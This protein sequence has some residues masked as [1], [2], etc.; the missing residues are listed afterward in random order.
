VRAGLVELPFESMVRR[1]LVANAS[2]RLDDL[3]RLYAL[4][5]SLSP[6]PSPSAGGNGDGDLDGDVDRY[7][8]LRTTGISLRAAAPSSTATGEGAG[9]VVGFQVDIGGRPDWR[10]ITT[11]R[12]DELRYPVTGVVVAGPAGDDGRVGNHARAAVH[13]VGSDALAQRTALDLAAGGVAR[14]SLLVGTTDPLLPGVAGRDDLVV[15]RCRDEME[16]I[17]VLDASEEGPDEAVLA[18]EGLGGQWFDVEHLLG[19]LS[20]ERL[21]RAGGD[22]PAPP[23]Y[24]CHRG[25]VQARRMRSFVVDELIDATWVEASYFTVFGTVYRT[26]MSSYE[27]LANWPRPRRLAVAH[28][29]ASR[30]CAFEVH[31]ARHA[32]LHRSPLVG[33]VR[34][35][36]EED[37]DARLVVDIDEPPAAADLAALDPEALL[38]RLHCV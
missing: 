11:R 25:G 22:R 3:R 32:P 37:A 8:H 27:S 17:Q 21:H 10:P 34:F 26:V 18:V 19:Q 14:V 36:V 2:G 20:V 5:R 1:F 33:T 24:V 16:A 4:P 9:P 7:V 13:V 31:H 28:R 30:L 35:S 6:S 23:L 29:I 12:T 38:V 15:W